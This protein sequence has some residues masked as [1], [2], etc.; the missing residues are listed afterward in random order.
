MAIIRKEAYFSSSN[1]MSKVR[2]L[3]WQDDKIS[4]I[5]VVQIAHGVCEHIGRY[6]DFARFLAENGFVVCGNDHIGHGKTADSAEDLGFMFEGDHANMVRD[7]NTLHNIMAKRHT[8]LPY[9]VLGHSMGSFLARI[10]TAAFGDRLS[11]AVFIGTG[12]VPLAVMALEDPIGYLM[13]KIAVNSGIPQNIVSLFEKATNKFYKGDDNLS[14]LSRSQAN[15]DAYREDPLCGFAFTPQLVKELVTLAVKVSLPDWASKV[16]ADLPVMIVSG[17]KDPIGMF[18]RG[19]LAVSDALAA[20]GNEPE[21][22]LYP[23]DRH[24]ILNEEDKDK[25]YGDILRFLK[26]IVDGTDC[27]GTAE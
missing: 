13:D 1:S 17:A 12:Q 15:R 4:P 22:I 6:D 21:V 10:Y 18:G 9:I 16:P 14:W 3:I 7:M 27:E 2:T 5:G 11:G 8:G 20:A 25:V 19:V 23:A 24:E 26:G